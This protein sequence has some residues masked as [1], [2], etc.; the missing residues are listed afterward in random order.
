VTEEQLTTNEKKK[1]KAKTQNA[2]WTDIGYSAV[3]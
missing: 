3:S 1:E 2:Q